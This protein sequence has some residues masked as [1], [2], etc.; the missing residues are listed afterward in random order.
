VSAG[1]YSLTARGVYD[2]GSTADSTP[3]NVGVTNA[4]G[5]GTMTFSNAS[6]ITIPD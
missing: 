6:A 5:A 3:A 4:P 2:A 1:S